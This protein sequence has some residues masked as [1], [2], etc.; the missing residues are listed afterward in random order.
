MNFIFI[1]VDEIIPH[2]CFNSTN[3][4]NNIAI[5][6]LS[7]EATLN[8]YV[9]PVRLWDSN[10]TALTE[11]SNKLGTI[12]GWGI[13]QTSTGQLSDSLQKGHMSLTTATN[14]LGG[15]HGTHLPQTSFCA[16]YRG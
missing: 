3:F 14:C 13:I 8:D 1:Q 2:P 10:R 12:I 4:E 9:Q 11:V 5:I 16:G 7:T 15:N 6:R